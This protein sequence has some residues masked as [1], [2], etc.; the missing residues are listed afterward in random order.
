MNIPTWGKVILALY[1]GIHISL[2]FEAYGISLLLMAAMAIYI[3]G[4]LFAYSAR[5]QAIANQKHQE[6]WNSLTNEERAA[7]NHQVA[8]DNAI[9][10][11]R[12]KDIARNNR[13]KADQRRRDDATE[14]ERR[15]IEF[16]RNRSW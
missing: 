13:I 7:H 11:D 8:I 15:R 9:T 5:R 2:H 1:I 3:V 16:E 12:N 6:W 14:A 4:K 10:A